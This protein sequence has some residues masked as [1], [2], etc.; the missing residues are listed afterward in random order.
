MGIKG[1]VSLTT[2]LWIKLRFSPTTF[3]KAEKNSLKGQKGPLSSNSQP[4]SSHW[5]A[6]GKVQTRFVQSPIDNGIVTNPDFR[7]LESGLEIREK[8]DFIRTQP[9]KKPVED[10]G[11]LMCHC[12]IRS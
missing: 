2:G 4:V 11:S 3:P 1:G 8:S 10:F 5:K 7:S 9:I 12:R 6:F